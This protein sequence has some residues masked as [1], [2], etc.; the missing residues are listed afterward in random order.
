MELNEILKIRDE[1]IIG[2][3]EWAAAN[4]FKATML[5]EIKPGT[6]EKI[7]FYYEKDLVDVPQ[8][9]SRTLKLPELPGNYTQRAWL[10]YNNGLTRHPIPYCIVRHKNKYFFILRESGS[11]EIR[12]IGK[13]GLLGGHI[14]FEDEGNTQNETIINA[15]FRELHEEAGI[16][17]EMIDNINIKGFIKSNE[18]VDQDHL[19]LIYE[20]IITT[21][22]IKAEEDGV[23]SGIWINKEDLH[24]HYESFENWSKIVY[25]NLLK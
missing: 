16:T 8:G 1:N 13:K 6:K 25:D 9:F 22:N 5:E 24:K 18:G 15:M 7:L 3:M 11:G 2:S 10:E 20:I 19:G 4:Q 12:L 14:A 21:D 23:L 17:D